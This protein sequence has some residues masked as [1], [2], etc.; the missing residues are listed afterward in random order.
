MGQGASAPRPI[1]PPRHQIQCS[2]KSEA[3][4]GTE[5]RDFCQLRDT[6]LS[7]AAKL[8]DHPCFL[9][10]HNIYPSDTSQDLRSF[11]PLAT[12]MPRLGIIHILH[13]LS[14][15][16]GSRREPVLGDRTELSRHSSAHARQISS[17][18]AH[19]RRSGNGQFQSDP[20]ACLRQTAAYII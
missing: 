1:S 5:D 4:V 11:H 17:A 8:G 20:S 18:H 9:S 14:T 15:S 16:P 7:A 3:F 19:Q 6:I 2:D 10:E 12:P 13:L